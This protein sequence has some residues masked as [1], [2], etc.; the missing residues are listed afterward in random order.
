MSL[1]LFFLASL[2]YRASSYMYSTNKGLATHRTLQLKGLLHPAH[3]RNTGDLAGGVGSIGGG[4]AGRAGRA[5]RA[6]KAGRAGADRPVPNPL[7]ALGAN[8]YGWRARLKR[9]GQWNRFKSEWGE[10]HPPD[11]WNPM[12][13]HL[14]QKNAT[15]TMFCSVCTHIYDPAVDGGGKAFDGL[16]DT[17]TCP[18]CAAPKSAYRLK[19]MA[20]GT[21]RWL[22]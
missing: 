1:H 16:P 3:A 13:R 8:P 15:P 9:R 5:G 2:A 22:H 10:N 7:L 19:V 14:S 17:W 6:G 11:E 4:G 21:K 12:N 20:D 18:V